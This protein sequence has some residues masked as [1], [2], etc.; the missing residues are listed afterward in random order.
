MPSLAPKH[1]VNIYPLASTL[2]A[3]VWD[4]FRDDERGSNIMLPHAQ[5]ALSTEHGEDTQ[6]WLTCTT[7]QAID[8]DPILELV[9]SC[10]EGPFGSY[11]IFIFSAVP[12]SSLTEDFLHPRIQLLVHALL[13]HVSPNRV[14]SV[15]APDP[16]ARM[17]SRIWSY[18][19]KI[20]YYE[21]PYYAAKLTYCTSESFNDKRMTS[22]PNLAYVPR[23]ATEDDLAAVAELCQRFSDTSEPFV[24]TA[25]RAR[26]EAKHLIR[27]GVMW[28]LEA[29]Q[30][31][32]RP[33]ISSIVAVTRQSEHVAGITKVFTSP[34]WRQ[35]GCA[36]RLARHVTKRLLG[37][38]QCVVLYVAHDNPAAAGVYHR[39]GFVG[40]EDSKRKFEGVDPW[41]EV[42][43][44]RDLVTL[45]HW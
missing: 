30:P 35:R 26:K 39:V 1:T 22:F 11:P 18:S 2:P 7:F 43:F 14:F 33:E 38:K 37:K 45:G 25:K 5:K 42:G 16:V 29:Q 8:A 27:Q 15:F 9:L 19:T 13:S 31:G 24:L 40:L 34:S 28:V 4:A 3:S 6:L 44:D 36:E 41:L 20:G 23:L 32:R 17:F 10:T 21:K 12:F